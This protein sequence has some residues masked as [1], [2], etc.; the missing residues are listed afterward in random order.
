MEIKAWSE[1]NRAH[2]RLDALEKGNPEVF[3]LRLQ[4]AELEKFVKGEIQALKMRAG[5]IKETV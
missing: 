3:A 1:I 4:L 2:D 5:K